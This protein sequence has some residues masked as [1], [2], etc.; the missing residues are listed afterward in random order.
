MPLSAGRPPARL[1]VFDLDGTLADTR[2]VEDRCYERA[3]CDALGLAVLDRDWA[4]YRH[5][6]DTGIAVEA[7]ESAFGV[8]PAASTLERAAA[9]FLELLTDEWKAS[10]GGIVAVPGARELLAALPGHGWAVAIATGGW[11]RSALFKLAAAGLPADDVP[12]ASSEDGPARVDIVRAAVARAGVRH[13]RASFERIVSVGD[14]P[15]DV[16]AAAELRLPFLG[17]ASGT[18]AAR[19]REAGAST[20]VDDFSRLGDVLALMGR[21]DAPGGTG[22]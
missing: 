6:S 12:L 3:V 19:L 21:V 17:V 15:W 14:A 10:P 11:R 16:R 13:G 20:V 22:E 7:Y 18:R 9:R 8:A 5:V 2:A 4:R 1:A